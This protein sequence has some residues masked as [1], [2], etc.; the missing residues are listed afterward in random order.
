MFWDVNAS[1]VHNYTTQMQN[2]RFAFMS[3]L[4]IHPQSLFRYFFALLL[5]A[6]LCAC[7]SSDSTQ[8]P[9]PDSNTSEG[10][11]DGSGEGNAD[12][13]G[14]D[15]GV[16][17]MEGTDSGPNDPPATG[18]FD[19]ADYTQATVLSFVSNEGLSTMAASLKNIQPV[20]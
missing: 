9:E 15:G 1:C 19:L 3:S 13:G 4:S 16:N 17:E 12:G 6:T 10:N 18:A 2:A 14:S 7:G 20:N 8:A 11:G 5:V